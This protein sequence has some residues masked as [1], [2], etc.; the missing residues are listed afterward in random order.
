MKI[1]FA[2]LLTAL[3]SSIVTVAKADGPQAAQSMHFTSG[4]VATPYQHCGDMD[5]CAKV[6]YANGDVLSIYSEG[7]ALCQPYFLHFILA[8]NTGKTRFEFSR[9]MNLTPPQESGH[10]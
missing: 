1:A 9:A 10:G 5:V 3:F 7:A 6:A 8:D 2:I 4:A